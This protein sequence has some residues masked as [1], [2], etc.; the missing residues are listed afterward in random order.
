VLRHL[1][2]LPRLFRTDHGIDHWEVLARRNMAT[3]L[4]LL[5]A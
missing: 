1:L 5:E 4:E 2:G 3:E